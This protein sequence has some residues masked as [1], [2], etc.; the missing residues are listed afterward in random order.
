MS[1]FLPQGYEAPAAGGGYTKFKQGD[2]VLRI[3]SRPILGWLDWVEDGGTRKPLR[4]PYT[5]QP[6]AAQGQDRV[7]HFWAMVVYNYNAK[8]IQVCE[9]TQAGIRQAIEALANN[10]SWGDPQ[11][12]D[13]TIN[14]H[15][16]GMDTEYNV[17]P[18]PPAPV[19]EVVRNAYMDKPVN[20]EALYSG[21]DPFE[22][23][24]VPQA[25]PAQE[26]QA[27]PMPTEQPPF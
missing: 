22:A 5:P 10:P 7:K 14:R 13:L 8:E 4:Y 21:G 6:P 16:E 11:G 20:L 3:L 2:T 24:P 27:A 19:S 23:A 15:G 25:Q 18:T 26:P 12:Y 1:D 17:I 9:I